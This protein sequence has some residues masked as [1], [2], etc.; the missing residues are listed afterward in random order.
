MYVRMYTCMYVCMYAR[1]STNLGA[2]LGLGQ[3]QVAG[4]QV[5][6]VLALGHG[7]VHRAVG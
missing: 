2:L 7:V 3:L 6:H 4:Q 1:T 5:A